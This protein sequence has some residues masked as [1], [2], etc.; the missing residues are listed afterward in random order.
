ML[1]IIMKKCEVHGVYPPVI[2]IVQCML[3]AGLIFTLHPEKTTKRAHDRI[4]RWDTWNL[5]LFAALFQGFTKN[6]IHQGKEN[7]TPIQFDCIEDVLN[8]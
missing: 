6:C 5:Q 4:Q 3:A 2:F 8:L 1:P 7:N